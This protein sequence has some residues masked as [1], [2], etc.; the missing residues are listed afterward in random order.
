LTA[1]RPRQVVVFGGAGQLGRELARTAPEQVEVVSAD[2]PSVDL[3]DPAAV[4]LAIAESGA[5]LVI[6]AAAYTAVDRAE[7][8]RDAAFAVNATG[9][10]HVA[11]A[12]AAR[13][14]RLV[15]VSTDFVFD[16]AQSVPYATDAEAHPLSVYGA[17]KLEGE[18]RVLE[19]TAGRALVLRTAWLYATAGANF[20]H[21]MLRLI[22][23]LDEVRVVA[24][25]VGTPT[26]AR[27]L[28]RAIWR[29]AERPGVA[30]IHHWT[31]AGIASWYDFAIAIREEAL[32]SG[33]M[34]RAA[35]VR[36]IPSAE[37]PAPARR[38]SYSVLA[39]EATWRALDLV[40]VHWRE[41]LR[42]ML[43]ELPRG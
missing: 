41:N 7:Q 18:R 33:L 24:D 30:G 25:Q 11:S 14:L 5:E 15:H 34:A 21:T 16:G 40:P 3:T 10:W 35:P 19:A 17:S 29:A 22:G 42:L 23:T 9:A 26:W 31:D 39:K 20:V 13:D 6:N 38:P 4:N 37:W 1:L 2:L 27:S 43:S 28:A 32:A 8:E 36:P 12:A